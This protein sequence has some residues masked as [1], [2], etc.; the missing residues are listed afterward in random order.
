MRWRQRHLCL[1]ALVALIH[2]PPTEPLPTSLLPLSI[3]LLIDGQE[4]FIEFSAS[5]PEYRVDGQP[6][7]APNTHDRSRPGLETIAAAALAEFGVYDGNAVTATVRRMQ[8]AAATQREAVLDACR[9]HFF[10]GNGGLGPNAVDDVLS[11]F[12]DPTCITVRRGVPLLLGRKEGIYKRTSAKATPVPSAALLTGAGIPRA[13]PHHVL[14][15]GASSPHRG[16]Y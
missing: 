15:R 7:P 13:V 10:E 1:C 12:A 4:R 14:T 3:T 6:R 9:L 11:L 8:E 16:Q 5:S 2:S